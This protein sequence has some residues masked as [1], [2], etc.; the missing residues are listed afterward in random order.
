M[1]VY[2]VSNQ[3]TNMD[4]ILFAFG[5]ISSIALSLNEAQLQPA[6]AERK[7][8]MDIRP[9]VHLDRGPPFVYK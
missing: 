4:Q 1:S 6:N 3:I 9:N 7:E 5:D 2:V 8:S